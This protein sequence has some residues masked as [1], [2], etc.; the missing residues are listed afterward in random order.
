MPTT[1]SLNRLSPGERLNFLVTNR[2]P[3]RWLTLAVGRFSKIENLLLAR[4]SIRVW[5]L[6]ADDLR[7]DEAQ[8][9]R[10]RSLHDCFIRKLKPGAR[11]VAEEPGILT[12]PC[13][14]VIG[15]FGNVHEYEVLQAKGFPYKLPDLLGS[16]AAAAP[17]RNA[18]FVTLRLKSSMYHHFHA[19]CDGSV[20]AVNYISGDTWNV[21]P[22]AL[23]V[24]ENLFCKNER[25]VVPLMRPDGEVITLVAVAA[26]LVASVRLDGLD[27]PLNL[28]YGGPNTIELGRDYEKG[29]HMGYFEHGST[30]VLLVPGKFEFIESLRTG[31]IIRMGE[32]LMRLSTSA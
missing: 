6:F 16:T 28:R 15:E 12:S 19:P 23:K 7:L 4:L 11:P 31:A 20:G 8:Q 3:R 29:A 9:Q 18:R 14:A 24:V 26:I 25:V 22:V 21:N 5:Q 10:F 2:L 17:Y 13:D 1:R 27:Y 32:P 30:I